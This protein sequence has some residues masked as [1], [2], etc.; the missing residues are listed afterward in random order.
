MALVEVCRIGFEGLWLFDC[1][2]DE[3]VVRI[4]MEIETS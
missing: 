4:G 3:C 2:Q 1:W